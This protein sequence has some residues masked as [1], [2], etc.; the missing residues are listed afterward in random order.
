M[1]QVW[2]QVS[3]WSLASLGPA[4]GLVQ[5][6]LLLVITVPE[7]VTGLTARVTGGPFVLGCLA[8][9]S[10]PPVSFPTLRNSFKE[11]LLIPVLYSRLVLGA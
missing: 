4:S 11:R 7:V 8:V 10:S 3:L 1:G 9:E 6:G 2:A 5:G